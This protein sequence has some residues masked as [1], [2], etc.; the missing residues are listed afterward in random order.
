MDRIT[1]NVARLGVDGPVNS[2][3]LFD[4][5]YDRAAYLMSEDLLP[6]F[7]LSG[8]VGDLGSWVKKERLRRRLFRSSVASGVGT[9]FIRQ[10]PDEPFMTG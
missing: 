6:A 10:E 8:E 3:A 7:D 5:C 1:K 9:A 2:P 4:R